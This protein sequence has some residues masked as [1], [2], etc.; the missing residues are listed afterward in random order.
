MKRL[1]CLLILATLLIA[2]YNPVF[3]Q[4]EISIEEAV[5][6]IGFY[7]QSEEFVWKGN[8]LVKK[9]GESWVI[10]DKKG[11]HQ[12]TYLTIRQLNQLIRGAGYD[13]L[14]RMPRPDFL[15]DGRIRVQSRN[16]VILLDAEF[17]NRSI[18]MP[19]PDQGSE[20][21]M[22][23]DYKSI[24]FTKGN[25]IFLQ[26]QSGQLTQVTFDE[27]PGIV[28]GQAVSRSEF[29]ISGGLFWSPTGRYLAY[30]KK[31]ES[32]VSPYPLVHVN[33]RVAEAEMIPYPMAGMT[34]EQ[35]W[36]GIYDTQTS[37][38]V[39]ISDHTFGTDQY[40]TN[41]SWAPDEKH[42][43]LAVLNREQNHMMLNEYLVSAGKK[44]KTLFEEKALTYVEPLRAMIFSPFNPDQFI[45]FSERDGFDHLYLYKTTGELISQLTT[46]EFIVSDFLGW[47]PGAD[48]IYYLSTAE[49]PLER[50]LYE[51]NLHN[52]ENRKLTRE[53]GT[54]Q[55]AFNADFTYFIDRFS[56][57]EV[58][59]RVQLSAV[60]SKKAV[61]LFNAPNPLEN[62]TMGQYNS[63]SILASDGKT[64]LYGYYLLP[65][66]FKKDEKY[67]MIV[68]V[69]GGPHAQL[70][71]NRW[72]GGAQGWQHYMAQKG[73]ICMTL[74]NRGSD[75]R[76][77]DFE[78][79]IHRQLGKIEQEDQ[80]AAVNYLI[81][82][83]I[84]DENRIGVHGW[85]Y[86]GFMTTSLMADHN[87]VFSVGVAGGPVIDWK[88]YEVMYGE[89]YMDRPD[90]NPD[91]YAASSLL[92]KA[93]A[94]K[95]RLMLI[96]GTVDP[97]VVWQNSL[98][99]IEECVRQGVLLD[100]MVYPGHPHNVRGRDRVHL[101]KTVT[102]YFDDHLK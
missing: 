17:P 88:Y 95:G 39:L 65:P 21:T 68:Y 69:Y 19:F 100:Y 46:G 73:Y 102:R 7:P 10:I 97:T 64:R 57:Y 62:K 48:K 67:P 5:M 87:D 12:S 43:Y 41:L 23:P 85:S 35:V 26:D 77:R 78:H 25:N 74:D 1:T 86:G 59:S 75:G 31:D 34:S 44:S 42:L 30:Y 70:V 37:K 14:S 96:H 29:G 84:V 32:S 3:P 61:T 76:G 80:M 101:M 28:N 93:A 8:D 79:V 45:W 49:S 38:T 11:N 98:S 82:L 16:A 20:M 4:Q 40:L 72:L 83:G 71:T 2:G 89:R 81:G 63:F 52:G 94:I 66:D 60:N 58:P 54:H 99:F 53:S 33:K 92:N 27:Y 24:A 9:D 50:H 56:S 15:K 18:R 36:V 47:S 91:G 22:A 55:V 90:E 6:G 13:T 51:G